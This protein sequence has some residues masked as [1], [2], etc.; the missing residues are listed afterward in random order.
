MNEAP[1]AAP[2]Q[3]CDRVKKFLLWICSYAGQ[4]RRSAVKKKSPSASNLISSCA[5][6]GEILVDPA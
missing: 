5:Q 4:E 6:D 3:N 2:L 1:G